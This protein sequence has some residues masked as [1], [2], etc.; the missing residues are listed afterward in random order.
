VN[1]NFSHQLRTSKA[2]LFMTAALLLVLSASAQA[3]QFDP[4]LDEL[5]VQLHEANNPRIAKRAEREIWAIWHQTPDDTA[6]EIMRGA[7]TALDGRDFDVAISLLDKLVEYAPDFAEAWNQ[8]AIVLYFA[9]DYSGSLRDIEQTLALEPRHFG[10][11]AGRGQ[12]YLRLDE[13]ELA[14]QAFES[15]LDRNPWMDNISGQMDM[16]RARINARQKSI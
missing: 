13:L 11:M 6:L 2:S 4:K 12:V 8:R 15:A 10:A 1:L 3:D 5:F 7:R 14:L 9:E 16:I